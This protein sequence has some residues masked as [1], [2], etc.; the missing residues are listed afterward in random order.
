MR[1]LITGFLQKKKAPGRT[2]KSARKAPGRLFRLN[3]RQMGLCGIALSLVVSGVGAG[4][5]LKTGKAA[6]WSH[7]AEVSMIEMSARA[8]L[9]VDE[10]M[11]TGR[12]RTDRAR[13]LEAVGV[14]RGDP[15]LWLD[16]VGLQARVAALP[17]VRSATVERQL[18]DTLIVRLQEREPLA[19]WQRKGRF[20]LIDR[21][22]VALAGVDAASFHTLP[23]V[24][25]EAAPTHADAFLSLLA[26]EPDLST[27][28]QAVTHVGE[29]RWTVHLKSGVDV[30]LPETDAAMAWSRLAQME[31]EHGVLH[32]DVI[33]IDL[34]LPD[35]FV[36]RM[37]PDAARRLAD[38]GKDT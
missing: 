20:T 34:R 23:V 27:R 9:M 28:V 4:W 36:V 3:R 26:A 8:G 31:R 19:L 21:E 7:K 2:R 14:D 11:V 12:H 15:I 38:P 16:L 18:P 10:I 30:L 37:A 24:I 29:R 35:K 17:W 32:R 22:G 25:G 13:L 6:A 1:R 5:L 33:G